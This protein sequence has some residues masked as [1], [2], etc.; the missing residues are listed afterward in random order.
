[1]ALFDTIVTDVYSITNRPDLVAETELAVRQATIQMHSF[2]LYAK[3]M[4]EGQINL[5][6]PLSRFQLDLVTLLP[7][8]R[9]LSYLRVIDPLTLTTGKFF[10]ILTDPGAIL[11]EYA[12]ERVQICYIAGASLNVKAEADLQG[13]LYGYIALP[14]V[15]PKNFYTSWIA[16]E[17]SEFL[18]PAAAAKIFRSVGR[19][20]EANSFS[21]MGEEGN[22]VIQKNNLTGAAR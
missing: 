13:L 16:S 17:W 22:L 9:A 18:I 14:P 4:K 2:D 20:E 11:D 12:V 8:F 6:K 1:M 7:R 21:K 19:L 10:E 15:F 3:D 5:V